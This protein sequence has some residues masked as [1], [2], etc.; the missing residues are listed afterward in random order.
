MEALP[1]AFRVWGLRCGSGCRVSG[2]GVDV[3]GFECCVPNFG[4]RLRGLKFGFRVW[5]LEFG[6]HGSGFRV[7]G[8]G[9][10][11]QD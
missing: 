7:S 11:I 2:A 9:V 10:S 5:S 8:S 3:Q 4:C 6:V 1:A